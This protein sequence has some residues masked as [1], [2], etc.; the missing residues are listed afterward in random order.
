MLHTDLG[1]SA[2]CRVTRQGGENVGTT[3]DLYPVMLTH[4][5]GPFAKQ[6]TERARNIEGDTTGAQAR[7]AVGRYHERPAG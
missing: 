7:V 2:R 5:G 3:L 6:L 1:E 4:F